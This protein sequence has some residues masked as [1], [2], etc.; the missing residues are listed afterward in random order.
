MKKTVGRRLGAATLCLFLFTTGCSVEKSTDV[1]VS[2]VLLTEPGAETSEGAKGY[3]T[4]STTI[5]GNEGKNGT[6]Y[7]PTTRTDYRKTESVTT[8]VKPTA[9]TVTSSKTS[10]KSNTVGGSTKT[11]SN[12]DGL[13]NTDRTPIY[14]D[15]YPIVNAQ[16]AVTTEVSAEV[17]ARGDAFAEAI[18]ENF[19]TS[20]K[21][22]GDKMTHVTTFVKIDNTFY[23]TYYANTS[24]G[25]EDPKYQKARL[26]YCP[27]NDPDSKTY[28]DIQCVGDKVGNKE[29][30]GVYDT[31]LLYKD[32]ETLYV[33]WTAELSGDYYRLYRTFSV[34]TGVLGPVRINRLQVGDKTVDF[35]INGMQAA[36]TA[37]GVPMRGMYADIGIMQKLTTRVENGVTYYYTGA[38]CGD[39]NFI[40]KSKDLETWE[41]VA[42]PDFKNQS[43]WENA[44]YVIGDKVYYFV[45]QDYISPYGFLTR[46]DL[47]TG[48]WDY[49]VLVE[50]CQSRGD[51]IM[52]NGELYLFYA[53]I[54]RNHIGILHVDQ[55]RLCNSKVTAL[56]TMHES[57][58][59]PF[60]QYC[61]GELYFS[62]T[63]NRQ[64]VKLSKFD[65]TS[66]LV[67]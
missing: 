51:F 37:Q 66:I 13:S 54:N 46:Y 59:Y 62:Y 32:T 21:K 35:S 5:A 50:D 60:V 47:N 15:A 39:H 10:S 30:W 44:T 16:G 49:P 18:D 42:Q 27:A 55:N 24:N 45:R 4:T 19:V 6:A 12:A 65:A 57:C 48:K 14:L 26:V 43:K 61:D 20:F 23:M 11:T 52:Y 9:T 25:A 64:D 1:S 38:Y 2:E 17:R 41:Y 29:V 40:M 58:F 63:M 33:E 53:P 34:S 8:T 31:V 56:A 22:P 67:P 28:M 36:F 3:V 7:T